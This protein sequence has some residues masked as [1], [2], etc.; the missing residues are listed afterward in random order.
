[1]PKNKD[2]L[3]ATCSAFTQYGVA[4]LETEAEVLGDAKH[5]DEVVH[6]KDR[7]LKLYLRARGYCLRAMDVRFKGIGPEL[8]RDPNAALDQAKPK[9]K[10]VEL[11]Y[12]TA[13]SWGSAISLGLDK[14]E[15]VGRPADDSRAGR[16]ALALDET[17]NKGA[18]PEMMISLDS[19]PDMLGGSPERDPQALRARGRTAAGRLA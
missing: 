3:V 14:P 17:W 9:K 13:A 16:K 5:H 6:L 15:I 2:L 4:F 7:A 8:L 12:W 19:V 11:L 18:L 1:M 10:D